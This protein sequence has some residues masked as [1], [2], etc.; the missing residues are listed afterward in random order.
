MAHRGDDELPVGRRRRFL[1][2]AGAALGFGALPMLPACGGSA[3]P[4]GDNLPVPAGSGLFRHGVAS[5]DPLSD[6]VVLWTR[7]SPENGGAV[8]LECIVATDPGLTQRVA[9]YE[10][11][12]DASRDH[13][14]KL[15]VTGLQPGTTY[16]YRFGAATAGSPVGRTRTLPVGSPTRLRL[17]VMSCAQLGKG[18]FNAYR[19]VAERA[20]LD[21]VLHLGDY[22][23]EQSDDGG[24]IRA[25]EP[26]NDCRTLADYRT[27][28]AQYKRDPDLQELHR[29]HPVV[30][31][32]DDHD[33]ASDASASGQP[34]HDPAT[35]SA[36]VAAALQA[37]YEWMPIRVIDPADLRRAYRSFPFGDLAEI[38]VLRRGCWR[39]RPSCPRTP[40]CRA[41]SGSATS[42]T[43]PRGTSWVP[44]RRPGWPGGCAHRVRDGS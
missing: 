23:Y 43:T 9:R 3:D 34:L 16:Y 25:L 18:Y 7:V 27:R 26:A 44:S 39:D 41:P 1:Q 8:A 6:R 12:T 14:V 29:Q 36:R 42:S 24:D 37:Y 21:L 28:H 5:G 11:F 10:T 35:W 19:R 4:E 13:T 30:A 40:R 2:G 32:W 38:S 33:I 15:D 17:A 22:L 31:I 20:D